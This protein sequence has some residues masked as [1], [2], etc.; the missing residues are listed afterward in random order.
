[1]AISTIITTTTTKTMKVLAPAPAF[2]KRSDFYVN[3]CFDVLN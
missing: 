3:L 1:M 2:S